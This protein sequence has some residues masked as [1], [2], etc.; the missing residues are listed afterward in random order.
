[1]KKVLLPRALMLEIEYFS[2]LFAQFRLLIIA[3]ITYY[4]QRIMLR[5]CFVFQTLKA[6]L[7]IWSDYLNI[8]FFIQFESFLTL[9]NCE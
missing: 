1:M 5:K 3:F 6:T 4:G 8:K 2:S 7:I 9:K